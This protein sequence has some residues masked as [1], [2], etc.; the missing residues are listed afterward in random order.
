MIFY[1]KIQQKATKSI[2]QQRSITMVQ[3][4][5]LEK[6]SMMLTKKTILLFDN[7]QLL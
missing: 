1:L 3:Q 7:I 5:Q 6:F 2:N 4:L